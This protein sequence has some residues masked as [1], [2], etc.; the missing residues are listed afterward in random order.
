[1]RNDLSTI[2]QWIGEMV[3]SVA[4]ARSGMVL[5]RAKEFLLEMDPNKL[6]GGFP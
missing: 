1:M 3:K 6:V 2:P 5:A 4:H